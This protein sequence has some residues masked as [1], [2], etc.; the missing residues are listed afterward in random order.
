MPFFVDISGG[1]KHSFF[2]MFLTEN[3]NNGIILQNMENNY[4]KRNKQN[5]RTSMPDMQGKT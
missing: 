1:L 3:T 2:D 4:A 5:G